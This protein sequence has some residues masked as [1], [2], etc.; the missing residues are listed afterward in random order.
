[1]ATAEIVRESTVLR[2]IPWTLYARMRRTRANRHLRMTYHE[3]TL[4]LMSPQ[5]LHE[6]GAERLSTIVKEVADAF[7]IDYASTRTTT[8]GRPAAEG[9][10]HAKEP[11]AAFY[12]GANEALVR[13]RTQ[14]DLETLPPPDL[15]IEVDHKS[16]SAVALPTYAGLRVPEV[17]RFDARR[18][19]LTFLRLAD[20]S[21]EPMDR[22]VALPMLTTAL[23]LEALDAFEPGMTERVW[24]R[25]VRA[26]AAELRGEN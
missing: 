14:I 26:W 13:D 4:F 23:V 24:V 8:L 20:G 17:W 2:S 1:M 19:T 25:H 5:Y 16:D 3:G 21:Y 10:G 12:L 18:R 11:D 6:S 15:A 9:G 7:A 22:S